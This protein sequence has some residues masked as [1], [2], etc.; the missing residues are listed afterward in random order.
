MS[1]IIRHSEGET[2]ESVLRFIEKSLKIEVTDRVKTGVT[3]L[4]ADYSPNE[5]MGVSLDFLHKIELDPLDTPTEY[6]AK[7]N[8]PLASYLRASLSRKT[9]TTLTGLDK[10]AREEKDLYDFRRGTASDT[11]DEGSNS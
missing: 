9:G 1:R 8:L 7:R 2:V 11:S 3:K 10:K 4:C 6:L 5:V